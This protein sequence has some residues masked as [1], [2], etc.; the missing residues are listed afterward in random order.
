MIVTLQLKV[1]AMT[2]CPQEVNTETVGIVTG[3]QWDNR[4][5][6][7]GHEH[8]KYVK[9]THLA[10]TICNILFNNIRTDS[11][12][13]AHF[14]VLSHTKNKNK[15]IKPLTEKLSDLRK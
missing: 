6:S 2:T 5:R 7:L 3:I 1:T 9:N 11:T 13:L 15:T 10:N 4:N 12:R 8:Q 14:Q